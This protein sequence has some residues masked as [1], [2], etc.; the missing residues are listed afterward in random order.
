MR[1]RAGERHCAPGGIVMASAV[2]EKVAAVIAAV[3]IG[4]D[5]FQTVYISHTRRVP[6]R[7]ALAQRGGHG[8]T[9][10]KNEV[11]WTSSPGIHQHQEVGDPET[12]ARVAQFEL[13]FRMPVSGAGADRSVERTRQHL[14]V[15][16]RRRAQRRHVRQHLRDG[17]P[18]HRA[19]RA[20]RAGL[21]S[22]MRC[23]PKLWRSSARTSTRCAS[24]WCR[25]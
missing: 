22:R 14:Q 10:F 1:N 11:P 16:R 9:S 4:V 19:R 6:S 18:P 17:A 3:R 5:D 7:T 12:Q 13:A 15:V 2:D 25:I 24:G 23:C 20:L 21:P 8:N